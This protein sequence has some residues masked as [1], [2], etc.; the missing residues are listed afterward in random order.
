MSNKHEAIETPLLQVPLDSLKRNIRDR[1]SIMDDTSQLSEKA[2]RLAKEFEESP[3]ED[4]TLAQLASLNEM[5]KIVLGAKEKLERIAALERDDIH[6]LRARIQHLGELGSPEKDE[7]LPWTRRRIDRIIVDHMLRTGRLDSADKLAEE[8][9]ITDLVDSHVFR[10]AQEVARSLQ[11][12]SCGPA[13][14]WCRENRSRLKKIKSTLEFLLRVQEYI[15]LVRQERPTDALKYARQYLAPAA[16]DSLPALQ[17]AVAAIAFGPAT[18][19]ARYA[20]LF[21]PDRWDDLVEIFLGDV[22]RL[23]SLPSKSLLAIH[24]QAGLSALKTPASYGTETSKEDPLHLPAFQE[25]AKELPWAKHVHSKLVCAL[26]R[27]PMDEHNPPMVLPNGAVYSERAVGLVASKNA[28]H[29]VCP[30]SG[31]S[32]PVADMRRAYIM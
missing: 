11:Q 20:H 13:L 17:R 5:E 7:T 23:N 15:E 12:H 19:C 4:Q 14:A 16:K 30:V 21:H 29:M 24:L 32:F 10:G 26:T 1:K 9:G 22:Y 2:Q 27:E 8:C 28:G 18:K 25:L 31:E 6:R 3:Q